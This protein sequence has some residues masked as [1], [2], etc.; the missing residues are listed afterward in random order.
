MPWL[1]SGSA[2]MTNDPLPC[3]WPISKGQY[4]E[5]DTPRKMVSIL[6]RFSSEIYPTY[7]V[8]A[9]I[10]DYISSLGFAFCESIH[11]F[12]FGKFIL[13]ICLWRVL[14]KTKKIVVE[15][16]NFNLLFKTDFLKNQL[17]S[18]QWSVGIFLVSL[19]TSPLSS[20]LS[21]LLLSTLKCTA[22]EEQL[23]FSFAVFSYF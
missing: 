18:D 13:G 20:L 23:I 6:L 21:S 12:S 8:Y 5:K 3:H 4:L 1:T 7:V 19:F 15:Q 9:S 14:T 11:L 16:E 2:V 22:N 10:S 17:F